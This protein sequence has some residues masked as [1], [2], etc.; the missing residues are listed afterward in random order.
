[1]PRKRSRTT[2]TKIVRVPARQS[3]PVI[4]VT[5][6]RTAPVRRRKRRRS[7]SSGGGGRVG[8]I[9]R[10]SAINEAIGGAIYGFAVK[11]GWIDKLPAIPVVGRTGTAAI[12]LDY[13]SRRGGGPMVKRAA[14][15]AAVIAGYQLGSTGAITGYN[16]PP[17]VPGDSYGPYDD[18]AYDGDEDDDD[19]D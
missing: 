16:Y 10:E 2:T 4:K 8:G 1:M 6:P 15:A 11:S 12:L 19:E 7:S 9:I 5:A 18:A 3:A 14:T 17:E 13:L